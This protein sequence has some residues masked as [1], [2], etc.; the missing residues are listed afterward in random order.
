MNLLLSDTALPETLPVLP[1]TFYVDLSQLQIGSCLGCFSCWVKTP[2]R[3]VLRDDAAAIYPLIAC[4]DQLLYVSR[5]YCGSY[6]VPMKQML[7]RS[8]P[9]QQ[10]FIRLHHGETHH[11][12]RA[13]AEKAAVIIAY[14]DILP[15]EQDI[16]RA[17]VA[18]NAYNMNFRSYRIRF[19]SEAERDET[20]LEEVSAWAGY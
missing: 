20:I 13:V 12:Q 16:F 19:V 4:S 5:V 11:V 17:L 14:G 2:G 9:V 10:A 3:C 15:I 18:R 1:E 8:S 6:D 7:E